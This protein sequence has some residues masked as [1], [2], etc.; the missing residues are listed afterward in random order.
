MENLTNFT[1]IKVSIFFAIAVYQWKE[2]GHTGW[3]REGENQRDTIRESTQREE[4]DGN[5][6]SETKDGL[7]ERLNSR[8]ERR[9]ESKGGET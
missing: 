5:E 6:E 8:V 2:S 4:A 9:V 7:W 1:D 3:K